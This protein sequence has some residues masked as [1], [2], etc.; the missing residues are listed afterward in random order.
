MKGVKEQKKQK[1]IK[2]RKGQRFLKALN[3]RIKRDTKE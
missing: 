3:N 2:P 1:K